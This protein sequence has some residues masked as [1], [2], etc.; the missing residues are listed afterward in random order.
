MDPKLQDEI[1]RTLK[2]RAQ[3]FTPRWFGRLFR[4]K[5]SLGDTFWTGMFGILLVIVPVMVV[6]SMLSKQIDIRAGMPV[7]SA[8]SL[9]LAFYWAGVT[10]AVIAVARRSPQ[11][12]G[13]RWAAVAFAVLLTLGAGYGGVRGLF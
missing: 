4:A 6:I 8:L 10:A 13:W 7:F 2:E 9:L 3:Y 11:A 5:L 1:D 12:G